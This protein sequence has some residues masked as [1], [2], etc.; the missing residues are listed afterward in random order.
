MTA[1]E[2]M[3]ASVLLVAWVSLCGSLLLALP[4]VGRAHSP[5]LLSGAPTIIINEILAHS[6][7]PYADA[8][9]LYNLGSS[10]VDLSG[11]LLT[12]NDRR[13]QEEWVRLPS[14]ATISAGGYYVVANTEQEWDFGLSEA[15]DTVYLFRPNPQGGAP[16]RVD[17]VH[18]GASPT[19]ISFIR[20][21]DAVGQV[22]FPMQESAP[23]LGVT[24][25]GVRIS[26]VQIEE[27]MVD[28]V[29]GKSEYIVLA[30]IGSR[31]ELLY[32]PNRPIHSWKLVGQNSSGTDNEIFYFPQGTILEAGERIVLSEATPEVFRQ[33]YAVPTTVR[34]FGPLTAGLSNTG[35]RVALAVPQDPEL[36][37]EIHY[38]FVDEVEYSNRPPWPAVAENGQALRRISPTQYGNDVANWRS[39]PALQGIRQTHLPGNL[40]SIDDL[41]LPFVSAPYCDFS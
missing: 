32:D 1:P 38:V 24:N 6:D 21:V 34:I 11:W 28:P 19:N 18:F 13:P 20:Y 35:E 41:Y 17:A 27:L 5:D 3:R 14:G 33:E 16:Q 26:P 37:S 10:E 30:N 25:C 12:D 31:A 22:R 2:R 40:F 4:A 29:Q 39:A 7:D 23:T 15:G 36:S 8:V 9:E